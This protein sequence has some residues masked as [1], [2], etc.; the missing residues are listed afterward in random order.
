[1]DSLGEDEEND[2][3]KLVRVNDLDIKQAVDGL[4]GSEDEGLED[5]EGFKKKT[6]NK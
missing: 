1:M 4:E 3:L 2:N 5:A 6:T